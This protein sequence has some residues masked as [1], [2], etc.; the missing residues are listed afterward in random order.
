MESS[1]I[2]LTG[3]AT[4][5]GRERVH[6]LEAI[7]SAGVSLN[8]VGV[9]LRLFFGIPGLSAVG[10]TAACHAGPTVAT[11]FAEHASIST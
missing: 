5:F 11:A 7:N 2:E 1:G 10:L 8:I 9:I 3:P 4:K 6:A